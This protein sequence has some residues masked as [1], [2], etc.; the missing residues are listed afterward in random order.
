MAEHVHMV[1]PPEHPEQH[2][3]K[4][5]SIGLVIKIGVVV[6]IFAIIVH[7]GLYM[8]FQ[9]YRRDEA[10][11]DRI[12]DRT[13]LTDERPQRIDIPIQ[14]IP[15]YH[16][17][18]PVEDM[19]ALR[20]EYDQALSTYGPTNEP[21]YVRIPIDRAMQLAIERNLFQ[22]TTQPTQQGDHGHAH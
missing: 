10:R 11:S 22:A 21:G 14:G 5:I 3:H 12:F 7:V 18:T 1:H 8:L 20:Q 19:R 17:N 9:F 6:V 4:D 16:T 15:G 13:A 2:E